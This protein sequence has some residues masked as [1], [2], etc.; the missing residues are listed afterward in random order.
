MPQCP[1]CG[2]DNP[3]RARFCLNCASP[4]VTTTPASLAEE[5]KVVTVLFSDLVG[6]TA[7]SEGADPEDV[8]ARVRPYHSRL[9]EE[10]EGY[11]GTVE[12]FIGDAVMAVF[13]APVAHEDDAERAVRAGLRILE[14]IEELNEAGPGLDLS[15]RIGINTGEA[16]VA[17]GARP[18]L[19]EGM[20]TGDVVNTASRLQGV[21]PVGG[22]AVGEGTYRT[23]KAVFDYEALEAVMVKGKTE[24]VPVWRAL[25]ARARFGVDVT[26]THETPLVGRDRELRLLTDA[27]ERATWER[28][29]QLVTLVGEPGVGKSRLVAELFAHIDD[30][31]DLITWRQGRCL[32]YGEGIT[33]WALGEIVK[34]QAGILESDPP[35]T[36]ESKLSEAVAIL[37]P[38]E[39]ERA[40]F[41]ARLRPL[42][43]LETA[44]SAERE[45]TFAAWRRFLEGVAASSPMVMVVEDLHWA[46]PAMLEFAE[47]LV[48]YAT[49]V[50]LLVVGTARPELYERHPGWAGGKRNA[51]TISLSPLREEDTA[52]LVSAL[53]HQA[54]LPVETQALLLERAG[55]NPL[56]A[57]EFV[58]ML[59]DR[60]LI[61]ERG[62][63]TAHPSEVPFPE[64]V[65]ALIAARLDTLP[66]ERKAVLHDASVIGKVFWSGA[67]ASMSDRE[68]AEVRAG[69]HELARKEL[70]RPARVSSVE[71]QAEYSFWHLLVRDVAYAQIP[72]A[73]RA[74]RH[75]KAASWIEALAG[76][77]VA[78][79][80]ELLAHHYTIALDLLEAS[81]R[82]KDVGLVQDAAR[83]YL[84][85]AGDRDMSL[86]VARAEVLYRRALKILPSGHE[87]RPEA[88]VKWAAAA[89]M[90]GEV[91]Q[92]ES[93]LVEAIDRL[94]AANDHVHAA[95][96]NVQLSGVLRDRGETA[97]GRLL[98]TEALHILEANPPG[99]ELARAYV[100]LVRDLALSGRPEECLSYA[101]KAL[102]LC[103]RLG[104]PDEVARCLQFVGS[105]RVELGDLGGLDDLREALRMSR[106]LR[107]GT[108]VTA[109]SY[110]NLAETLSRLEGP[111]ES[112]EIRLAG[113]DFASG[114]GATEWA[115]TLKAACVGQL[116]EVGRW[117]EALQTGEEVLAW[118]S[119]HAPGSP[120]QAWVLWGNARI[121]TLRGESAQ[122][123][124]LIETLLPTARQIGDPQTLGPALVAVALAEGA[125]GDLSAARR[126]VEEYIE[127]TEDEW[128]TRYIDQVFT[129][130]LRVLV[131][132]G[133]LGRAAELLLEEEPRARGPRQ[134]N[135]VLTGRAIVAEGR[136]EIQQASD[137]YQ[138][139]VE[140]WTE[141]GHVIE[142]G[143]ALLGAGRCL[144]GLGRA[145]EA[146]ARLENAREVFESLGARP[147]IAEAA[148]S[149]GRASASTS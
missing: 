115:M 80:A 40:W 52:R 45:E 92:A 32:P 22:I 128:P 49:D 116:E 65:H 122:A 146:A 108:L 87:L 144:L 24:P 145:A 39:A 75:R 51:I 94:R 118:V 72:R 21:A 76:D 71:G 84:M 135:S 43:G 56:Y 64:G 83:R 85:I 13:G 137:L 107:L 131:A 55:G 61:D 16:V 86:D 124:S 63:L 26:R 90:V 133:A 95:D 4:L 93:A 106:E 1:A 139:A 11:G 125:G 140:R 50:P 68:D 147:L 62:R 20:V 149:L 91:D 34:A 96:A 121:H 112:L 113:I 103:R 119:E 54:V 19:G 67:V 82:T 148:S 12:K 109:S 127:V 69:L 6:F 120:M 134:Q 2:E 123:R 97:Q 102:P 27:F 132:A 14:A 101:E 81:G 23:T 7:A 48:E 88:L 31:P 28:S 117:N 130:A 57:E 5:R 53:L 105:G 58:R 17:L 114:R 38:D 35:E 8:R 59:S 98:L 42:V 100:A 142:R 37:T 126:L 141:F 136:G 3:D 18:E 9:R 104:M 77:R 78:D 36:A 74:E 30:L 25:E 60:G 41:Q 89:A 29:P 143:R 73:E 47:Y 129:D 15:V 44:S 110:N 70:V 79:H 99:P 10:I 111:A 33:F 138:E 66:P 46:D